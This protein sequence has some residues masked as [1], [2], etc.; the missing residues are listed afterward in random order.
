MCK[1]SGKIGK[2]LILSVPFLTKKTKEKLMDF[3]N[4]S[5][6]KVDEACNFKKISIRLKFPE[7]QKYFRSKLD[8][9][10][11]NQFLDFIYTTGE[12]QITPHAILTAR[13]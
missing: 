11:C 8:I 6:C 3:F 13:Y 10:H 9:N 5:K 1:N 7:N 12:T 4:S 2:I